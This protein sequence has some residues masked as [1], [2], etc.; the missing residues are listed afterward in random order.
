MSSDTKDDDG[1]DSGSDD[2]DSG[3]YSG[4]MGDLLMMVVSKNLN[5]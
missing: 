5:T 3:S 1:V 2:G 4:D